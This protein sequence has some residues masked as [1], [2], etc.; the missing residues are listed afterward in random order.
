M[1][2][3][4]TNAGGYGRFFRSLY[5]QYLGW[6]IGVVAVPALFLDHHRCESKQPW[7]A[8]FLYASVVL[9]MLAFAVLLELSVVQ[10]LGLLRADEIPNMYNDPR[11]QM[12]LL[13]TVLW[14]LD[15][16]TDVAFIF[17]AKDCESSLWWA[18]LATFV[19]GVVFGQ[20]LFNLCFAC[21]DCDHELPT[22]FGFV[23]L[24]FKIVNDAVRGVLPFDPDASHL[25]VARPVTLRSSAHLVAMEKIVGDIAQVSIQILF[26][27]TAKAAHGFVMLSVLAGV[28]HGGLTLFVLLKECWKDEVNA[29][30]QQLMQGTA[31]QSFAPSQARTWLSGTDREAASSKQPLAPKLGAM[32]STGYGGVPTP[33]TLGR[34]SSPE[35]TAY[36]SAG[37]SLGAAGRRGA[38]GSGAADRGE[39]RWVADF[40]DA[41]GGCSSG[42]MEIPDLL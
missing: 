1:E 5:L 18:S 16:Y 39:E 2:E 23:L 36:G 35:R 31:L 17:V 24:D 25:P 8:W 26:L 7:L 28:L 37:A 19:F 14:K 6:W 34:S 11:W 29:Q 38:G 40:P 15:S 30:G 9:A 41:G 3:L 33:S 21:S 13:S 20:L 42:A 32:G 22:S 10:R 4:C 12:P 27:G